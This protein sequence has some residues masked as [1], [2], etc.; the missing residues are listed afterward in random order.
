MDRAATFVNRGVIRLGIH[1]N[2]QAFADINSGVSIAPEL[3]DAYV[4]RGAA[5]I[6]LGKY[7]EALE[8]LNKGIA[9]GPHRPR[10]GDHGRVSAA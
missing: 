10:E 9:L 7:D 8:D 2:E 6:A 3:G 5:L 4:D 1:Q